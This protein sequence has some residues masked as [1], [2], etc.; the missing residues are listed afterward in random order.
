MLTQN[1]KGVGPPRALAYS[2]SIR[3]RELYTA[4]N[5]LYCAVWCFLAGAGVLVAVVDSA[6]VCVRWDIFY[7]LSLSAIYLYWLSIFTVYMYCL[8]LSIRLLF[9][10]GIYKVSFSFLL[11]KT[12]PRAGYL[13][14]TLTWVLIPCRDQGYNSML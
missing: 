7:W 9:N 12:Y 5:A 3:Y 11:L 13:Y 6:C 8:F 14:H 1:T 2:Y 4:Y 10:T